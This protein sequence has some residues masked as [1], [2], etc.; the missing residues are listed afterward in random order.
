MDLS[1]CLIIFKTHVTTR[2]S[3]D[4]ISFCQAALSLNSHSR[5]VIEVKLLVLI[6]LNVLIWKIVLEKLL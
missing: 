1:T 6:S 3:R 4:K 5:N 2:E